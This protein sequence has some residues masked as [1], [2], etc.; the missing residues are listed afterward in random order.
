MVQ[1]GDIAS[2]SIYANGLKQT[3]SKDVMHGIIREVSLVVAGANPGAFIEFVDM[4]HGEGGEQEVVL[5]AYEPISLF[6]A[7]D[8]PPLVHKVKDNGAEDSKKEEK[9]EDEK[10]IQDVVD[11]M[12]EE[13]QLFCMR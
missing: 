7:T 10:T 1:H 6:S 3:P 8:K 2:L 13:Q 12:T 9:S 5:S 4:A 11:G